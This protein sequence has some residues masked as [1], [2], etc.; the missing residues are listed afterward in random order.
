MLKKHLHRRWMLDGALIAVLGATVMVSAP[1]AHA[2]DIKIRIPRGSHY[3][4]VQRLN[5]DGVEAI[6]KRDYK[7]AERLFYRAYLLDPEDPFTLNNLGYISEMQGQLERAQNFYSLAAREHSEAVVDRASI[8]RVQ[9]QTLKDAIVGT[10]ATLRVNHA[11]VEAIRLLKQGRAQEADIVLEEALKVDPKNAFTLNNL[12]VAKEM[13]GQKQEALRYYDESASQQSNARALLA[14]RQTSR[15]EAIDKLAGKSAKDLRDRLAHGQSVPEQVAEYNLRGVLAVNRND[16]S[17]AESEFRRAYALD[18]NSAFTLN[19]IAYVAELN[20]DQESADFFYDRARESSGANAKIAIATRRS[21]EGMQLGAVAS[22]NR[23]Q[24]DK[25]LTEEQ[26]ARRQQRQPAVLLR[27][28]NTPIEETD[29][30]L[31]PDNQQ[32]IQPQ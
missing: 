27:R 5:R 2:G 13:E 18:P 32:P 22:D 3:T 7:K 29:T 21:A 26:Q 17:T 9:G 1:C 10:D 23:S 14:A 11:N 12:G 25:Q 24:V 20:G 28:D 31:K 15:G 8:R 4:P 19:N 16:L 6:N 30:P